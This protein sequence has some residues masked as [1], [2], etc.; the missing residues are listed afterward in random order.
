[1]KRLPHLLALFSLGLAA[2]RCSSSGPTPVLDSVTP[3]ILDARRGGPI[4][5]IG[6]DFAPRTK[7]NFDDPGASTSDSSFRVTVQSAGPPIELTGVERLDSQHLVAQVS[8][9]MTPGR[10]SV[11]L[12]DPRGH[13]A[14][15]LDALL[16]DA[17]PAGGCAPAPDGGAVDAGP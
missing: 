14:E 7:V 15:R 4:T 1:M 11:R 2:A 17:C 8:A 16:L 12:S 13:E 9:G 10:Y 3:A 5:L 6:R